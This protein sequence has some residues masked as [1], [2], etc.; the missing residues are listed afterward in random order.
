MTVARTFISMRLLLLSVFLCGLLCAGVAEAKTAKPKAAK[1]KADRSKS[2]KSQPANTNVAKV[3]ALP[4]HSVRKGESLYSIAR[5]HRISVKELKRLNALRGTT[6]QPGQV[7]V[8]AAGP[9]IEPRKTLPIVPEPPISL[10]ADLGNLQ[11]IT[12][13]AIPAAALSAAAMTAA[14]AAV[15]NFPHAGV[16]LQQVALGFLSTPYRFGAEGRNSTDCSG[17]VQQVFRDCGL[18]LPRTAREQYAVGSVVPERDWQMGDLLFFRT[19]ARYPSHVGIYLGDGKMIHASRSSRKVVISS[20]DRP[21]YR[22][23]FL[24]ARRIATF[25]PVASLIDRLSG[26]VEEVNDDGMLEADV[27]IGPVAPGSNVGTPI[28]AV[29]VLPVSPADVPGM[30]EATLPAAPDVSLP[31][32]QQAALPISTDPPTAVVAFAASTPL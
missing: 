17:F 24:G 3:K 18:D 6:I 4:T 8:L 20:I 28:P 11:P 14:T 30:Q 26:V 1:P 9:K 29:E 10:A 21:Y 23:R 15:D 19:Y 7:L 5:K 25:D 22:K 12:P 32:P 16:D 27:E 13:V 2:A 31:A